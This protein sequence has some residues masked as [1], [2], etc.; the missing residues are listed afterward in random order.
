MNGMAVV[1][2]G[3]N[4]TSTYNDISGLSLASITF[5]G[6]NF[7]LAGNGV[8]LT[9]S[10]TVNSGVSGSSISLPIALSGSDTFNVGASG[11]TDSG[12]ISGTGGLTETGGGTLVVTGADTYSG[13]T[14][15]SAGTFQVGVGT[16][17][18]SLSG[19]SAVS[20][21]TGTTMEWDDNDSTSVLTLPNPISGSGTLLL[22]GQ[23]DVTALQTS[24]YT[25]SGNNSGFS[26]TLLLE[27]SMVWNTTQQSQV[28]SALIDV[29]DR[30]TM[31]FNG[32]TFSN[33]IIVGMNSGWHD[34][35]S[36]SDIVVGAIRLEY[37]NTLTGN[38]TL[39][40]TNTVVNGDATGKNSTIGSYSG[41]NDT[42][43]GVISG[44]GGLAM[45]RYTSCIEPVSITLSGS[46]SNTYGGETVVDGQGQRA[47]LILAKTGGAV[48]VPGN[49]TVQMGSATNG[50]AN[51][52]MGQGNQ[53]GPNVC[54]ELRQRVRTDHGLRPGGND[55]VPGR[56][57]GGHDDRG[58]RGGDRERGGRQHRPR[59]R[60]H[61][62]AYRRRQLCL[63]RLRP[64]RGQR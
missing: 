10:V 16:T 15:V 42:L 47:T 52:R 11:L 64:R 45:S 58:G 14:V 4:C 23:D 59:G 2:S 33:N 57:H 26:G 53:F 56:D 55:A 49:S 32:G 60:R 3:T 9:G 18:G 6:N 54:D 38:I 5:A 37:N 62:G 46:G 1:F 63:Q 31:A 44:P 8:T 40:D 21:A 7:S 19:S 30:A 34:S 27:R 36:G 39:N 13:G 43:S 61:A 50:Q 28:G 48:A 24:A 29:E 51:L 17:A 12:V 25:L 22:Q 20:I 35:A 41:G